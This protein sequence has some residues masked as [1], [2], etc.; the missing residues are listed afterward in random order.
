MH[1]FWKLDTEIA[2]CPIEHQC[3]M[4]QWLHL[5][6]TD[7]PPLGLQPFPV[8]GWTRKMREIIFPKKMWKVTLR[9]RQR[10][11][12]NF[13]SGSL[14]TLQYSKASIAD[15]GPWFSPDLGGSIADGPR[16]NSWEYL[17]ITEKRL[18]TKITR[19][20]ATPRIS[21]NG[22]FQNSGK[23]DK[24]FNVTGQKKNS[25]WASRYF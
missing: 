9:T 18:P 24:T 13:M 11:V 8:W 23:W 6:V 20:T 1:S 3:D 16:R 25:S 10:D 17:K 21:R 7:K 15:V 22:S 5:R 4:P 19:Y 12:K 2:P 14:V